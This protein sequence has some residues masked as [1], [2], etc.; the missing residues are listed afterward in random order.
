M[1]SDATGPIPILFTHFG[2]GWI[3][4][5]EIMLLDL[6]RG[7]DP[8]RFRPV[9]WCNGDEMA[10][11]CRDAGWQTQQAGFRYYFDYGSPRFSPI[12]YARLVREGLAL[13][14]AH[15]IRVLHAN[16]AAPAQFLV[17]VARRARLPLLTHLHIG[18]LRRSRYALLLHQS[19]L[20]VGVSRQVLAG[21]LQDG[22]A[23]SRTQVIYNG[24]DF[25]RLDAPART[26]FRQSLGIAAGDL[27][28]GTAGS[29]IHRKGQD[30]L[31]R[32]LPR[33]AATPHLLLAGEGPEREALTRL[34]ASLGLSAR[35][36]FLGHVDDVADFYRACD[37]VALASRGDAFALVLAEA[38]Y[39]RKPVAATRVGGIAEVVADEMTGLLVPPEDADALARAL[40]RLADDPAL[41]ARLGAAG[42]NQVETRFTGTRMAA[43]FAGAYMRLAGMEA[44][45]L[46]WSSLAGRLAPYRPGA[47]PDAATPC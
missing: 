22:M 15:G 1:Q 35:V 23:T 46:G 13:V 25:A 17:P 4:G 14:R 27:V 30:V 40:Q 6:M 12:A 39:A 36:H 41:R 26:D 43:E 21:P 9:V 33:L 10:Q 11:S 2:D 16:S 7:L 32:A 31:L 34:A 44:A 8:A 3:R 28:V 18:Y 47:R 45:K 29:L 42:R 19:D 24:I 5:S 20:I 37:I 38:G